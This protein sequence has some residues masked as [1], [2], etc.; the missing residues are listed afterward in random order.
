MR[1]V[2]LWGKLS[3]ETWSQGQFTDSWWHG[4]P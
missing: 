2:I 1:P 4:G 3:F